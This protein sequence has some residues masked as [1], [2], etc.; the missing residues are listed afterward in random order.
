MIIR[1]I[2]KADKK[3]ENILIMFIEIPTKSIKVQINKCRKCFNN[4]RDTKEQ[5]EKIEYIEIE[6][7]NKEEKNNEEKEDIDEEKKIDDS[8]ELLNDDETHYKVRKVQRKFKPYTNNIVSLVMKLLFFIL[9]LEGYFIL[10]YFKSLSFTS[11]MLNLIAE[12]GLVSDRTGHN[13]FVFMILTEYIG[14]NGTSTIYGE[15]SETF[16]IRTINDIIKNQ[17]ELLI[18]HSGNIKSHHDE[19]NKMFD[20]IIYENGCDILFANSKEGLEDCNNAQIMEKGIHSANVAYWDTL[21]QFAN[22]F[23]NSINKE[24][25]DIQ[26]IFSDQRF[27][28][29]E[30]L[31]NRYF[32]TGYKM[33]Q[34]ELN[35]EITK[36]FKSEKTLLLT[37]LIIYLVFMAILYIFI[38][39][40]FVEST[41][42]SLW[43]TKSMLSIIPV[44]TIQEVKSIKEFLMKTSQSAFIGLRSD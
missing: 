28:N 37:F 10:I 4:I 6:E 33:L 19:Y 25:T 8:V 5:D 36:K 13:I 12:L 35:N 38:W 41:R 7:E 23:K 20:K 26:T 32:I 30:R 9:I 27:I 18:A 24:E 16:T 14:T 42:H 43:V 3:K 2:I 39:R 15:E 21:R 29:N 34:T 40:I 22:D 1:I 11:T 44:N 31:N 17:E